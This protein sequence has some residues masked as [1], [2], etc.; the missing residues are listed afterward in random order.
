MH[1]QPQSQQKD[2][3]FGTQFKFVSMTVSVAKTGGSP[4]MQSPVRNLSL[5]KNAQVRPLLVC[6]IELFKHRFAVMQD[7]GFH[8][9]SKLLNAKLIEGPSR[10]K[11]G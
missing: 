6:A 9:L 5:A 10:A 7:G 3:A 4:G 11:K 1:G 8:P 2:V